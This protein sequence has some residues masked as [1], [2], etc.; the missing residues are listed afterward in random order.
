VITATRSGTSATTTLTVTTVTLVSISVQPVDPFLPIGYTMP[1]Q[2]LGTYSDGSSRSLTS[3]VL[4]SSSNPAV[5]KISNSLGTE[6]R[7]T[8]VTGGP[9]TLTA[10]LP[11]GSGTTSLTVT[12]RVLELDRRRAGVR[13]HST[14][15]SSR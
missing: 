9:T 12:Q 15:G 7:V 5:A 11:G 13:L 10:T 1:L 14:G 4:W 2:A 8:G 3:Q 6:G